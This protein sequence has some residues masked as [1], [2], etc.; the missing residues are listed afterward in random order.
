MWK[1]VCHSWSK[2]IHLMLMVL[3]IVNILWY[4]FVILFVDINVYGCWPC[5]LADM[6]DNKFQKCKYVNNLLFGVWCLKCVW[7]QTSNIN[8]LPLKKFMKSGHRG[9]FSKILQSFIYG[10]N[11]IVQWR[12]LDNKYITLGCSQ[13][14]WQHIVQCQN[15]DNKCI[16]MGCSQ[17]SWR[18]VAFYTR[19]SWLYFRCVMKCHFGL[20]R[21]VLIWAF[22]Y[23]IT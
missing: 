23:I 4:G 10:H 9:W 8:L 14:W 16:T 22:L 21:H 5:R 1:S 11:K 13:F 18:C 2:D 17:F 6:T 15:F 20:R 3:K 12:N 19:E 7:R